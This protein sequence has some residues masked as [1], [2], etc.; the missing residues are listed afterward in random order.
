MSVSASST[1][2]DG[3]VC[4]HF[5][6]FAALLGGLCL[7][8]ATAG[9]LVTS[10]RVLGISGAVK[11]L[12]AKTSA[13]PEPLLDRLLWRAVFLAGLFAGA[14][15]LVGVL[16]GAFEAVPDSFPLW[17]NAVAGVLVG[18]GSSMGNGCTS[19]HGIC[20]SARLSVRSFLFTCVFMACGILVATFAETA[21]RLDVA[22]HVVSYAWPTQAPGASFPVTSGGFW[23]LTPAEG[24]VAAV[25]AAGGIL[26]YGLLIATGRAMCRTPGAA[27]PAVADQPPRPCGPPSARGSKR[28]LASPSASDCSD[29]ASAY[30]ADGAAAAAGVAD[31]AAAATA[32]TKGGGGGK[33]ALV[34]FVHAPADGSPK[35]PPASP[36][37]VA[38]ASISASPTAAN[39]P[40]RRRLLAQAL[41]LVA[42]GGAGLVFALGLGVS[43]MT[44]PTK[45]AGFLSARKS[46]D[47][48]LTFVMGGA[49]AVAIVAYQAVLRFNLLARPLFCRSWSLPSV[50]LVDLRLVLGAV[51]FGA[52]WGLAGLCPGPALVIMVKGDRHVLVYVAA[53]LAGILLDAYALNPMFDRV[54]HQL[55]LRRALSRGAAVDTALPRGNSYGLGAK[56][57]DPN[58]ELGISNPESREDLDSRLTS[59]PVAEAWAHPSCMGASPRASSLRALAPQGGRSTG[60]LTTPPGIESPTSPPHQPGARARAGA[61]AA[62]EE[63][64]AAVAAPAAG[65]PHTPM[66]I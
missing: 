16:P 37:A 38:A 53:M 30:G 64:Q 20:G 26:F 48:S 12:L 65:L 6:P 22:N 43:G 18:A 46:W 40:N 23:E 5:T 41:D 32:L 15:V 14:G 13:A 58:L 36:S 34:V 28:S 60:S 39:D 9:K 11:G 42:E 56:I 1:G 50:A 33:D 2:A 3:L 31:K 66:Q 47:P 29:T 35:E 24:T 57:P 55:S 44:H 17:R 25:T 49:V 45:V 10:G 54:K 21:A 7:G 51:L 52:G 59:R 8:I 4:L 61:R 63:V 27:V 62:V 19:G